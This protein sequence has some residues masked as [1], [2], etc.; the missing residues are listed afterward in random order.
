MY[1]LSFAFELIF[2]YERK[3]NKARLDF[4]FGGLDLFFFKLLLFLFRPKTVISTSQIDSFTDRRE[5]N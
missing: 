4:A 5:L 2:S 3:S 1:A